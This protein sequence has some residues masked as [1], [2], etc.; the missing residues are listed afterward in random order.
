MASSR[1]SEEARVI[2]KAVVRLV[3]FIA[4]LYFVAFLDRVNVG[5][6]ALTMNLDIGLSATAY[7]AGAGI[8]FLGYVLFEIPSNLIMERV[9][10]RIW[11]ARI[12][13]TWGAISTCS[14]LVTGPKSFYLVRFLLGVAEAGFFPGMILYLTTW[15]PASVRGRIIGS[16][17]IA[18]PISTVIGAPVSTA[19]LQFSIFGLAG[20]QTMFILEGLP[21]VI[22]GFVVLFKLPDTPADARWFTAD[23]SRML[24]RVVARGSSAAPSPLGGLREGLA[25]IQAWLFAVIYFCLSFSVHGL[26]FWIPQIIQS[27]G[28][29]SLSRIGWLTTIPYAAAAVAMFLLGRSSDRRSERR[30]HICIPAVAGAGAFVAAAFTQGTTLAVLVLSVGA[31][32][33]YGCAP[34]FW[35]LSTAAL[36]ATAAASGIALINS[37]G[38]LGGYLGG[39]VIG[40]LREA[41]GGHAAG[42]LLFGA[43]LAI[44]A[45]L[46]L[47]VPRPAPVRS[48]EAG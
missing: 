23:E 26:S 13:M 9:G 7:G 18:L 41:T 35:A 19:L 3:P 27:H 8:F 30:W 11:I 37:V 48:W 16:F 44:A 29:A 12:M 40:Q 28:E 25:S 2:A 24:A 38:N 20:W 39:A 46:S 10:A 43:A 14:A 34:P 21:A 4:V 32:G 17:L 6:A 1:S 47:L 42:L 31:I 33:V 22:L 5:Y 45:A 36:S 15:F